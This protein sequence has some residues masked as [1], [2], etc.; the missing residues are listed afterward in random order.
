[1]FHLKWVVGTFL[2]GTGNIIFQS[3]FSERFSSLPFLQ[4]NVI[5]ILQMEIFYKKL[6]TNGSFYLPFLNK[7]RLFD[8]K[9]KLKTACTNISSVFLFIFIQLDC[10]TY[11]RFYLKSG[12]I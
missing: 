12:H 5:R 10:K 3:T 2:Q 9:N 1:M 8:Q 6:L 11:V 7:H 4:D